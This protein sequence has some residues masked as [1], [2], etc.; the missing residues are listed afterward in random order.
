MSLGLFHGSQQNT[1]TVEH[2]WLPALQRPPVQPIVLSYPFTFAVDQISVALA[3]RPNSLRTS[4]AT[5]RN[6]RFA[7][8]STPHQTSVWETNL[9]FR[10]VVPFNTVCDQIET[11]A[12]KIGFFYYSRMAFSLESSLMCRCR[13]NHGSHHCEIHP[14]QAPHCTQSLGLSCSASVDPADL[15]SLT[16]RV[17][18]RYLWVYCRV[19]DRLC[20]FVSTDSV[21]FSPLRLLVL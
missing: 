4:S 19:S 3:G 1:R 11:A 6:V 16:Y 15:A 12:S 8:I 9:E 17:E 10:L 14:I 5:W 13:K 20:Y 2:S 18:S 21:L 7:T